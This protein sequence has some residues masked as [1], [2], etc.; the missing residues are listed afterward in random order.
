MVYK[1]TYKDV[2]GIVGD[3]INMRLVGDEKHKYLFEQQIIRFGKKWIDDDVGV[4]DVV[5]FWNN[6]DGGRGRKGKEDN[7][8]NGV[9]KIESV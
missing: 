7:A 4:V 8:I 6:P 3:S 1:I 5:E 2:E 9:L